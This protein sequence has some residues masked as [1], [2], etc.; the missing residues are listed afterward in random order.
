MNCGADPSWCMPVIIAPEH[1]DAWLDCRSGSAEDILALLHPPP[2]DVLEIV[3]VSPKLNNPR[4][5]GP[6]VQEPVSH[7][8]LL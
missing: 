3:E 7:P 6:E 2:E 5:E 8:P 1:F 4:N